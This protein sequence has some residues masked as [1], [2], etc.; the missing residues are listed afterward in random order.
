M[1]LLIILCLLAAV[2]TLVINSVQTKEKMDG[3]SKEISHLKDLNKS[4]ME[5]N[6]QSLQYS[7]YKNLQWYHIA[8]ISS[9]DNYLGFN[10][11]ANTENTLYVLVETNTKVITI[12]VIPDYKYDEKDAHQFELEPGTHTY[13]FI[14]NTSHHEFVTKS[15]KKS[16][17]SKDKSSSKSL[18]EEKAI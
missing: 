17:S 13:L 9:A 8:S 3:L 6:Q 7:F 2:V 5:I 11:N 12:H 18:A 15:I 14:S 4:L 16:I 10:Y 1:T